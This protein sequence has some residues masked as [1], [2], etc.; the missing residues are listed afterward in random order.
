MADTFTGNQLKAIPIESL[1]ASPLVA[2]VDAQKQLSASMYS[3]IKEVALDENGNVKNVNFNYSA[4]ENGEKVEKTISAPF[5]AM[6]GIPNLSMELVTIDFEMEISTSD[7]STSSTDVGA[8]VSGGCFGVKFSGS[9]SHKS[10]Q[11]RKSDTR[12]KYTFHVEAKKQD[13]PEPLMRIIEAITNDVTK[14]SQITDGNA[15]RNSESIINTQE[16]AA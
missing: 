8:S 2:V 12:S 1:V 10:E 16:T 7:T 5:I 15:P 6:T 4:V 11:T 13:T 14:P 3:F 9:V